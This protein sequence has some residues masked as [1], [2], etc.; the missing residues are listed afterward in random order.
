MCAENREQAVRRPN[1]YGSGVEWKAWGSL[2]VAGR[3]GG[4]YCNSPGVL[5]VGPKVDVTECMDFGCF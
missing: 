5:M 1:W 2:R 4:I 3:P